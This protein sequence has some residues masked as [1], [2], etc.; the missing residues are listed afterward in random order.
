MALHI[1]NV[2][3]ITN[4]VKQIII[5]DEVETSE[6]LT[7]CLE[8]ITESL[9]DLLKEIAQPLKGLLEGLDRHDFHQRWLLG[10]LLH[11]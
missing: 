8:V 7:L 11:Q 1:R 6:G 5:T 4:D 9:L 3:G 2:L 10:H